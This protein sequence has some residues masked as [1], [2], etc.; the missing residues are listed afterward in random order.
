MLSVLIPVYRYSRKLPKLLKELNG[1]DVEVLVAVDEPTKATRALAR[2]FK[3]V[4]F[5]FSNT[6][7][8]KANS[9]NELLQHAKGNVLVFLDADVEVGKNFLPNLQKAMRKC[10]VLDM[11]KLCRRKGLVGKFSHYEYLGMVLG[12][13]LLAGLTKRYPCIQGSA[14]AI[15]RD[16]LR[17]LGGFRRVIAEDL[18]LATR[19]YL[20]GVR[21]C[22]ST[23]TYV[24]VEPPRTWKA[25]FKQR[26]RWSLGCAEWI[27]MYWKSLLVALLRHGIFILVLPILLPALPG[28]LIFLLLDNSIIY[29]LFLLL[30]LPL[31]FELKLLPLLAFSSSLF[32]LLRATISYLGSFLVLSLIFYLFSRRMDL[33]FSFAEFAAYFLFYS[34]LVLLVLLSSMF[35]YFLLRR[36]PDDWVV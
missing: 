29:K 32:L 23:K 22:F 26:K 19:A 35:E 17:K 2:K 20:N 11:M 12:A 15:R 18:D 3:N 13:K 16:V 4:R 34:P 1:A 28:F 8:G 9:L 27:A 14:F 5:F 30:I 24:I 10:E 31:I 7:R 6:R 25:W 36:K 33:P 21:F